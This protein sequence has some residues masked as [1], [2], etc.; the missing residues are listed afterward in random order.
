MITSEL[1]NCPPDE[2]REASEIARRAL[3]LFGV[4]GLGLGAPHSEIYSWLREENLWDELSPSELAYVS[5]KEPT[6]KQSIDA[7]WKSE[8]LA[9][10]LWSLEKTEYLPAITEQCD[11]SIFQE[12]LPPYAN[13]SPSEFIASA[14]RRPD[15]VLIGM[16]DELMD[17]HW[18]VRDAQI[19]SKPTDLDIE[20]IQERHHAINWV[21][22][23][24]GAPWD[25]VTTDT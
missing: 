16:A 23:Y 1:D 8:A 21:I 17:Y 12:L 4:V 6:R 9:V 22:G 20:I 13:I 10:L 3:A 15:D 19:H 5:A 2:V 25:D 18:Q 7:T 24:D 14:K 11:T